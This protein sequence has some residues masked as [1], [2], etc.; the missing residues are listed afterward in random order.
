VIAD[1][2]DGGAKRRQIDLGS[3]GLIFDI[4]TDFDDDDIGLAENARVGDGDEVAG[5]PRGLGG[6]NKRR[7]SCREGKCA[8]IKRAARSQP[9]PV[10]RSTPMTLYSGLPVGSRA[11]AIAMALAAPTKPRPCTQTILRPR[12][13][14]RRL[15]KVGAPGTVL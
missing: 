7:I 3:G 4:K 1:R 8:L 13:S 9:L 12:L 10:G 6:G 15:L 11:A 2:A 14:L 5:D